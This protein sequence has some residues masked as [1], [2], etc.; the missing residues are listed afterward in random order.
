MKRFKNGKIVGQNA[1]QEVH[2]APAPSKTD[3]G[4][5]KRQVD[6][7][8][9]LESELPAVVARC[10]VERL[11]PGIIASKTLANLDS[12]DQ[13]PAGRFKIGGK[14]CYP[15]ESLIA[16]LRARSTFNDE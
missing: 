1:E 2:A 13:G 14:T 7:F 3:N 11:V 4:A 9:A 8:A 16:W 12:L 10:A 5:S 15:R 6:V